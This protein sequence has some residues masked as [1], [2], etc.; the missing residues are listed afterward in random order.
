MVFFT[1]KQYGREMYVCSFL[2]SILTALYAGAFFQLTTGRMGVSVLCILISPL[3]LGEVGFRFITF[4]LSSL[5][6]M[7]WHSF[8]V[9]LISCCSLLVMSLFV[10]WKLLLAINV[11]TFLL[12]SSIYITIMELPL[13]ALVFMAFPFFSFP[14]I[15]F[16]N[17]Y[18]YVGV[19]CVVLSVVCI[20]FVGFAL[21]GISSNLVHVL[22]V[23]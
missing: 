17:L 7:F 4:H 9:F 15:W 12:Y 16:I 13:S 22:G 10:L 20:V 23:A 6:M 21:L 14:F 5:G 18:S 1:L 3:M 11:F 19:F 8:I 2:A